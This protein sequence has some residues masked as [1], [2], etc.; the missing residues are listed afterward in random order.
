MSV[1]SSKT[2]VRVVQSLT[3]KD[4]SSY[5]GQ[6]FDDPKSY[7]TQAYG[8]GRLETKDNFVQQGHFKDNKAIG[9]GI[10]A[11]P[12][13]DLFYGHWNSNHKRDGKGLFI[14]ASDKTQLVENYEDGKLIKR[15]KRRPINKES[16]PHWINEADNPVF[17]ELGARCG[18]TATLNADES[19]L[20]IIGGENIT[21][22]ADI[23]KLMDLQSKTWLVP[24]FNGDVKLPELS[25]HSATLWNNKIVIIGGNLSSGLE[26][27][28]SV[29]L[30]DLTSGVISCPLHKG[31][32]FINH[33]A[34]LINNQSIVVIVQSSVFTLNLF[35]FSW[36]EQQTDLKQLKNAPRSYLSH[37]AIAVGP[38]IYVFGGK[39]LGGMQQENTGKR[40]ERCTSQLRS[41]DTRDWRWQS[42]QTT[43]GH[44]INSEKKNDYSGL[45]HSSPD[46]PRSEHSALLVDNNFMII[47]GGFTTSNPEMN[48]V[49]EN[50][51]NDTQIL[52]ID[53]LRWT[54]M[55]P[56]LVF[57]VPCSNFSLTF[58][59]KQREIWLI[60]GRNHA[61]NSG[62]KQFY[63]LSLPKSLAEQEKP[64]NS[65]YREGNDDKTSKTAAKPA[66][67]AKKTGLAA[68][69]SAGKVSRI[70]NATI[71]SDAAGSGSVLDAFKSQ[72]QE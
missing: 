34:T 51:L 24:Q 43:V 61:E 66:N 46:L 53:G 10:F 35:N 5:S 47:F 36:T 50:F 40:Y 57:P 71:N 6:V 59:P 17:A 32:S 30:I 44:D 27:N 45:L 70:A 26:V 28:S 33:T 29:Y 4:G 20:V 41:L 11:A 1:S 9:Q 22:P 42:V 69:N 48:L 14:R 55:G 52:A 3:F 18:H 54:E 19:M 39:I 38:L 8:Y 12:N 56:Q 21:N 58:L 13:G 65:A 64:H 68:E 72:F 62:I 63:R 37:S 7:S 2:N 25:G 67:N 23:I 31:L 16:T 60:G 49:D 15:V